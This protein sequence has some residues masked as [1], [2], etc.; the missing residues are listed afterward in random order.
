MILTYAVIAV[1]AVLFFL[2]SQS[3][4]PLDTAVKY[5]ALLP[6][7]VKR[8]EYWRL[9][10][11][12][13]LHMQVWHVLMNMY[14]LYSMGSLEPVFGHLRFGLILLV[15]VI[16]G[17]ALAVWLGEEDTITIGISGGLYGLFAAYMVLLFKLGMLQQQS[18]MFS[19]LRTLIVN[20]AVNFMPNVSRLGHAGGFIAG[21]LLAMVM[22]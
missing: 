15:S 11:S 10:A 16:A 19:V 2:I 5:G 9:I 3:Q 17:N 18:V 14:S 12:G 4:Y 1:C 7:R 13:F 21:F 6:L 22:L 8:G 20:L